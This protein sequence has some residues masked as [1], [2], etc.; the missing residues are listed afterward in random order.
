MF[1]SFIPHLHAGN[2]VDP[3]FGRLMAHTKW[4]SNKRGT[5]KAAAPNCKLEIHPTYLSTKGDP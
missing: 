5:S 3:E 4:L 2:G 1:V